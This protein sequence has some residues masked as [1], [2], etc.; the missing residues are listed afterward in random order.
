[1]PGDH[2][3][4]SGAIGSVMKRNVWPSELDMRGKTVRL[5]G[6][7]RV[8]KIP[9]DA[10]RSTVEPTYVEYVFRDVTDEACYI[11]Q[12]TNSDAP[13]LEDDIVEVLEDSMKGRTPRYLPNLRR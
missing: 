8:V 9:E 5:R 6:T 3:V 2:G 4:Y 7:R 11:Y 10:E 12:N 1:M 13:W